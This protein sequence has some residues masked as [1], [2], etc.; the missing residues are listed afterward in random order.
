MCYIN[1]NFIFL[2]KGEYDFTNTV[3]EVCG[4]FSR[5]LREESPARVTKEEL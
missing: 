5:S 3:M 4:R 1:A 2:S